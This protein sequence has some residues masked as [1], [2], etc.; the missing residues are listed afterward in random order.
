MGFK[1]L[2]GEQQVRCDGGMM[3]DKPSLTGLNQTAI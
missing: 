1:Q 2:K 3:P